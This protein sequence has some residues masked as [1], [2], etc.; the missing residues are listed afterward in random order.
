MQHRAA[1]YVQ[2]HYDKTSGITGMN[3]YLKWHS[4]QYRCRDA[5]L[6]MLY[7]IYYNLIAIPADCPQLQQRHIQFS[8]QLSYHT[9]QGSRNYHNYAF[10]PRSLQEWNLLAA[11]VIASQSFEC[12][13]KRLNIVDYSSILQMPLLEIYLRTLYLYIFYLYNAYRTS[14]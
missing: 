2:N 12:F 4:L 5:R 3:Q 14:K 9:L 6:C 13:R 8:H 11:D 10:F 1:R 7:K